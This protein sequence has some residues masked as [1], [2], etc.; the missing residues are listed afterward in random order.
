MRGLLTNQSV[1]RVATALSLALVLGAGTATVTWAQAD[2]TE[3]PAEAPAPLE[4]APAALV[5]PEVEGIDWVLLRELEGEEI[6]SAFEGDE[7]DDW[8][9]LLQ[10]TGASLDQLSLLDVRASFPSEPELS[11]GF[12]IIRIAGIEEATFRPILLEWIATRRGVGDFDL[13]RIEL[14]ARDV[15]LLTFSIEQQGHLYVA[16]DTAFAVFLPPEYVR[17]VFT[18]LP[19]ETA[20]GDEGPASA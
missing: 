13:D 6:L 20:A 17:S 15:D 1:R 5:A 19:P 8:L 2:P 7:L 16:G 4:V 14:A 11:G 12:S 3:P 18:Q 10:R 9:L